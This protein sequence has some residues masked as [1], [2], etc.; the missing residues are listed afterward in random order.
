MMSATELKQRRDAVLVAIEQLSTGDALAVMGATLRELA[1]REYYGQSVAANDP[2]LSSIELLMG[3]DSRLKVERDPEVQ[4]FIHGLSGSLS[5][6]QIEDACRRQFGARAP[7]RSSI[8]RYIQRLKYR[9][10]LKRSDVDE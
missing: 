1:N 5:Y 8:H 9:Q 2:G 10:G 7:G 6:Q 4:A 3:G